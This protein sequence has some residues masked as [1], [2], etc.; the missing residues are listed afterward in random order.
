MMPGMMPGMM[1][2]T[3]MVRCRRQLWLHH[4]G[5]IHGTTLVDTTLS[6]T[7]FLRYRCVSDADAY[8]L[9]GWL[10]WTANSEYHQS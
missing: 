5:I 1:P 9:D 3:S 7:S 6:L 4:D 2:V 8:M 10:A